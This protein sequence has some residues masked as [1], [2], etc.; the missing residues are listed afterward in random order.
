MEWPRPAMKQGKSGQVPGIFGSVSA[1]FTDRSD[2]G[3]LSKWVDGAAKLGP[4]MAVL[5]VTL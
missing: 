1:R 4:S 5:S 2:A 3:V